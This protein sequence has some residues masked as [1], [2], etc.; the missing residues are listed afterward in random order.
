[1]RATLDIATCSL[2]V[3]PQRP[4]SRTSSP[5][6]E[7]QLKANLAAYALM[8]CWLEEDG[9]L[10]LGDLLT[11]AIMGNAAPSPYQP[12]SPYS[13]LPAPALSSP[14]HSPFQSPFRPASAFG[15]ERAN[16]FSSPSFP[17]PSTGSSGSV[18]MSEATGGFYKGKGNEMVGR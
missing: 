10:P 2:F 6:R 5:R 7:I 13:R 1:M 14:T 15:S 3:H 11:S 9:Q 12:Y 16:A 4:W 8:F 17:S 18:S